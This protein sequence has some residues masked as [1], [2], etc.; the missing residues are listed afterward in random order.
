MLGRDPAG[1]M[2]VMEAEPTTPR[3]RVA[4]CDDV[5]EFRRV[6]SLLISFEP[7]MEVVGEAAD[8]RAAIE[9]VSNTDVDVLLLDL[10]MPVMDG[11]EALPRI[12]DTAPSTRVIMLT[13]FGSER[14]RQ[15]ADELGA[16]GYLEKGIPPNDLVAAV[17]RA[18]ETRA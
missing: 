8:G 2:R 6:V 16:H 14:I 4:I 18:H 11:M 7:D 15:R 12:I 17:R 13:A 1:S 10:A 3:C 5:A 9:L